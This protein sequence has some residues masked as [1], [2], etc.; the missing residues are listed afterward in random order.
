MVLRFC[1]GIGDAAERGEKA[2]RGLNLDQ[3]NVVSAAKQ[4]FDFLRLALAQ[5]TVI[6]ENAGERV[7]NRLMKQNGRHGGIDA[8]GKTANHLRAAHLFA[9]ARDLSIAESRHRP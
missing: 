7:A 2:R 4:A 8:A 6:D 1:S 5:K 9:N 3:R